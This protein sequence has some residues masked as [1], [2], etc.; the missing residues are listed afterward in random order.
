MQ[1]LPL[2]GCGHETGNL[3]CE[4]D[5]YWT[6]IYVGGMRSYVVGMRTLCRGHE[7]LCRGNEFLCCGNQ[8]ILLLERDLM[9]WEQDNYNVGIR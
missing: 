8:I 2:Q 9:S 7:I 4:L 1:H 5:T 6:F 3:S